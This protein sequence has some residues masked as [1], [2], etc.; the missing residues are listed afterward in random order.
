MPVYHDEVEL[1]AGVELAIWVHSSGMS[2]VH[3][4]QP[5]FAVTVAGQ[6]AWCGKGGREG[7]REGG[8]ERGREDRERKS[9]ARFE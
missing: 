5:R 7:G 8:L 9:G 3:G 4:N 1:V 6:Q 2:V